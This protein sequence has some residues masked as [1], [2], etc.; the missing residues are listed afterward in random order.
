MVKEVPRTIRRRQPDNPPAHIGHRLNRRPRL[1]RVRQ[2]RPLVHHDKRGGLATRRITSR[3][4]RND[5]RTIT[6]KHALLMLNQA[7]RPPVN[8][9]PRQM[10]KPVLRL[11]QQLNRLTLRARQINNVLIRGKERQPKLVR[12]H[13]RRPTNLTGLQRQRITVVIPMGQSRRLSIPEIKQ[14]STMSR[15]SNM[16]I[17][18]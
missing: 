17:L 2:N 18:A 12:R 5:L 8:H 10:R 16:P 13:Q 4:H 11:P 15:M 1:L 9:P 14:N 3:R 6:E 7:T